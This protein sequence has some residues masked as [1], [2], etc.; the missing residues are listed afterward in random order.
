MQ[1]VVVSLVEAGIGRPQL[2]PLPCPLVNLV[3]VEAESEGT[4]CS[5]VETAMLFNLS[6]LS[7]S[8]ASRLERN[9]LIFVNISV[10]MSMSLLSPSLRR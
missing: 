4:G 1:K 10:L 5:V 9:F 7:C 6:E 8:A 3:A 2:G